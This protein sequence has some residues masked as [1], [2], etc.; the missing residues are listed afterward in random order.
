MANDVRLRALFADL[1]GLPVPDESSWLPKEERMRAA[2]R[3]FAFS[4]LLDR[5]VFPAVAGVIV[6][7]LALTTAAL[8]GGGVL[9]QIRDFA[10][11]IRSAMSGPSQA[12][13]TV[14]D[15]TISS[16]TIAAYQIAIERNGVPST[17]AHQQ[18]VDRAVSEALTEREAGR[19]GITA[20]DP[21][22]D[23]FIQQ[24][25]E[26]NASAPPQNQAMFRATLEGLGMTEEQ[27]WADPRT[28][29]A[30]R[31]IILHAKLV[32]ALTPT[33]G[34]RVDGEAQLAKVLSELRAKAVIH[35][36]Q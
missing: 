12:A 32:D 31:S 36:A 3:R 14:D 29:S 17:Q 4:S 10:Q 25:R 19:R 24:Q 16:Q 13:L 9:D 18:A 8:A 35:Y 22:V 5:R 23:A 11:A 34:S 2:G 33:G 6:L 15:I 27:Y 21:E 7:V 26:L 30:V 1:D 20:S 28:R